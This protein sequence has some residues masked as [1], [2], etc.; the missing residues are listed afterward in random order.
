[1]EPRDEKKGL[2]LSLMLYTIITQGSPRIYAEDYGLVQLRLM[3]IV[4]YYG[5]Q[6][7]VANTIQTR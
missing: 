6:E 7:K 3:L 5:E 4:I 2:P 1:M